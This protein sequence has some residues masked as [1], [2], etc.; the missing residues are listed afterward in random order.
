MQ[1]VDILL[2]ANVI[3]KDTYDFIHQVI[4]LMKEKHDLEEKQMEMMIT[5][6]AMATE[7]IRSG[8]IVDE[9]DKDIYAAVCADAD[10]EVASKVMQVISELSMVEYPHSEQ[11]FM[12]LHLCN[13][14]KGEDADA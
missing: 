12:L 6:L 2:E 1:R 7:R 14:M 13:S 8:S 10:F 4:K 3:Q 11:Q 5:H 9:M